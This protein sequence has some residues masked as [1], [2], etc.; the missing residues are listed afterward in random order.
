MSS[1]RKFDTAFREAE[2]QISD[3]IVEKKFK[4]GVNAYWGR[5]RDN[6]MFPTRSGTRI[7]KIR[8][9]RIG[10]GQ[11]ETGWTTVEDNG[12]FSNLCEEPPAEV[13]SHGSEDS[14]YGL[15][16][17]KIA[18]DEICL[19][20]LWARQ[21][22]ERELAH[23]ENHLKI[24]AQYF[25]N[26]WLR[27]RYI[28]I[29]EK[30]FV[31]L[32]SDN[33]IAVGGDICDTLESG[34]APYI[35]GNNGFVMWNRGPGNMPIIDPL[36]PVDER[37]VSVNVPLNKVPNI[38]ELSGDL[39]EQ[40][41]IDLELDDEN[42]P[43]LDEGIDLLD[44]IVPD[45]R[46]LRRLVQLERQQ[47]A[48]CM[49]TVMYDGKDLSRR[50]GI[51]RVIREQFGIRR[52]VHG[53][54]FYPD[55]VYNATLAAYN[56]NS[57]TTWPRFKR[58]FAYYPKANPNGTVKYVPN[59]Y[60]TRA[61]FGISVIFTPTVMGML[62]HPEAESYGTA[63]VGEEAI[64][65]AG[66]AVWVNEYDKKCNPKRDRGH[67]ELHFGAGIEPD[68]P[69]NGSAFFHRIDHKISLSGVNCPIP[70][71]GCVDSYVSPYC[72]E[73]IGGTETGI[74]PGDRGANLADNLNGVKYFI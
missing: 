5:V 54:K 25:W 33:A 4:L 22:P 35:D 12:C 34:C 26:E 21:M 62:H 42:M 55:D 67:W 6:G 70:I 36:Y 28:N 2:Q 73:S 15:E 16:K 32:V 47:E 29:V 71:L 66:N 43:M 30:K 64:E 49:P 40:A 37:Y 58:V 39:I 9:S 52:D 50:L 14:Y 53:M 61:P 41:A 74:A 13:L 23:F 72:Y 44:V 1:C 68:R 48:E 57:P 69:E 8:L 45:I 31:A 7:K 38:S 27:S 60:F 56:P 3:D 18:T 63:K 17:F 46:M 51:K 10:F 65:Y 24:A 20:L 59:P 11:M 19:S